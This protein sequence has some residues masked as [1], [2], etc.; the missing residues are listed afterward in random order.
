MKDFKISFSQTIPD[1]GIQFGISIPVRMSRTYGEGEISNDFI[2]HIGLDWIIWRH[3]TGRVA[4]GSKPLYIVQYGL[5]HPV[6][7][8]GKTIVEYPYILR[9]SCWHNGHCYGKGLTDRYLPV[10]FRK[11]S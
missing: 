7:Y 8:W 11:I 10:I 5:R 6:D 1:E 2:R 9:V 4:M 3:H